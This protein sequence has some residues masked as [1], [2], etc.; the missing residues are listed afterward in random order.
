[1]PY[2]HKLSR[3]Q[4]IAKHVESTFVNSMQLNIFRVY[5]LSRN[6]KLDVFVTLFFNEDYYFIQFQKNNVPQK[7]EAPV[8]IPLKYTSLSL[9]SSSSSSLL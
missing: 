5:E 9:S 1:M 7:V 6:G 8:F 2:K 4:K 3:V